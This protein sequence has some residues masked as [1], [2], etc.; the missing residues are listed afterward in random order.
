MNEDCW[1][2]DVIA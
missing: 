1:H 2:I